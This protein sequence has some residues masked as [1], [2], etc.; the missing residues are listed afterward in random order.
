MATGYSLRGMP[1]LAG[2]SSVYS[3][4]TFV[5]MSANKIGFYD[6]E[7]LQKEKQS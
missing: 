7:I 1:A 5:E 2:E 3:V 4:S 6:K